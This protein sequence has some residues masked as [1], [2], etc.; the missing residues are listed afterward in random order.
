[1]IQKRNINKISKINGSKKISNNFLYTPKKA[2][3]GVNKMNLKI[4]NQK[5]DKNIK[6]IN[7][8]LKIP[9]N[10]LYNRNIN[11]YQ[12]ILTEYTNTHNGN[13][14]WAKSLRDSINL[15][16]RSPMKDKF[17]KSKNKN[18][19]DKYKGITLTE[20]FKEPKFYIEDLDK[21]KKK[22]KKQK[23]PLSSILNPN[24][25]NIRHLFINKNGGRAKE[26]ASSLRNYNLTPKKSGNEKIKWQTFYSSYNK[27]K[28]LTTFLLPR[29]HEGQVNL[30]K[31]EKKMFKPYNILYKKIVFG[32]DIIKQKVLAIKRDYT[33]GGIGEHLNMA[34][35]NT[36]YGILNTSEAEN[37]LK[38]GTNSQCLFELNLRNYKSF[39]AKKIK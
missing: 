3:K 36:H 35:Y 26:F 14:S 28:H 22:R 18:S 34:N 13:L 37:I 8:K 32:N 11:D 19:S 6:I 16:N 30:K 5:K 12:Q 24:F 2:N 9:N 15:I 31:L 25:N 20:N 7:R 21:Y 23:R 38:T 1:M 17:M 10:L 27:N 29:T 33:Y 4:S 39:D